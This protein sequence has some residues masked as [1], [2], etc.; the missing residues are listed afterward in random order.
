MNI[1]PVEDVRFPQEFRKPLA[2]TGHC[3]LST[4]VKLVTRLTAPSIIAPHAV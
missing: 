3:I 1:L 2:Y 4:A